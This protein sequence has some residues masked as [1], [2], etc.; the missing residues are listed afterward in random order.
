MA[1]IGSLEIGT[2]I[3][4]AAV[5]GLRPFEVLPALAFALISSPIHVAL[6]LAFYAVWSGRWL[7]LVLLHAMINGIGYTTGVQLMG[8][9]TVLEYVAMAGSLISGL[10]IVINLVALRHMKTRRVPQA[11]LS[12]K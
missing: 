7:K 12:S 8:R 5:F 11:D 4:E 3:F 10:C 2:K 6:S 1:L 9:A